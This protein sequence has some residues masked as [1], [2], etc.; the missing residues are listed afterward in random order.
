MNTTVAQIEAVLVGRTSGL[1]VVAG[2]SSTPAAD[3]SP[4]AYL[5]DPIGY[6]VRKSG[7]TTASPFAPTSFDLDT[8]PAV[9]LD[10]LLDLA[11]LRTLDNALGAWT[12]PDQAKGPLNQ[13]LGRLAEFYLK[14][15]DSLRQKIKDVYKVDAEVPQIGTDGMGGFSGGSGGGAV[16]TGTFAYL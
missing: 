4:R 11:E 10:Q 16:N 2:I 6:A 7:G 1:L 13:K 15:A 5:V 9:N 3:A 14:R 8:V 12:E